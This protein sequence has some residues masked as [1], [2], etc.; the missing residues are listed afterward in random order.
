M[1][2]INCHRTK[3]IIPIPGP[4]HVCAI[5]R[6]FKRVESS[7]MK[8]IIN[9]DLNRELREDQWI[10]EKGQPNCNV[11]LQYYVDTGISRCAVC[12]PMHTWDDGIF[13]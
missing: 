7:I 8:Y 3:S 6:N 5:R 10:P 12:I 4:R 9:L 13:K 2:Q 1:V 11:I